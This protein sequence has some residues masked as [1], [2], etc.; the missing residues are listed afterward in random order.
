MIIK[1]KRGGKIISVYW[2]MVLVIIAGGIILMANVFYGSPYDVR[3]AEAKILASKVADCIYF[4][5]HMN[6]DLISPS[7]KFKE[8]FSDNFLKRCSLNFDF[9]EEFGGVEYY[10]GVKFFNNEDKKNERFLLEAGNSNW[11]SDCEIKEGAKKLV[12][13]YTNEFWVNDEAENSY[14]VE[15]KGIIKKTQKNVK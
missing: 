9:K 5:G 4:G 6:P 8:E 1:N 7:G 12:K 3:E 13:C 14:L 15:I 10:V 2:F 11:I